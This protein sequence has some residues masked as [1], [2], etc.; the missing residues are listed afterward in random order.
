MKIKLSII[1][2]LIMLSNTIISQEAGLLSQKIINTEKA[3][4]EKWNKGNPSG[5]LELCAED[6]V[7]FDPFTEKR[8]DGLNNLRELYESIR[9]QIKV[10]RYDM[11][12]PKVQS[13][14]NMA[15]LTYNL[16]S[17]TDT[18]SEKWNCTEVYRLDNKEWKIIQTHWSFTK[19]ALN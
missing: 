16:T 3:A 18:G 2:I 13:V 9:G 1:T 12:D 17:Y 8:L 6:V 4:L 14:D 11:I 7:Y 10:E 19:P 5:F 15:V